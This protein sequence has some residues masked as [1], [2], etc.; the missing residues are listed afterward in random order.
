MSDP[1]AWSGLFLPSL[2]WYDLVWS[3][4]LLKNIKGLLFPHGINVESR[5]ILD[6]KESLESLESLESQANLVKG[7]TTV[8]H[9]TANCMKTL[10]SLETL[11]SL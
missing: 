8:K 6:C 5:M 10:E 7:L 1:L 9:S 3:G 2:A 4:Q 11:E